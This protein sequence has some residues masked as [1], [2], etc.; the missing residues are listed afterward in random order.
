MGAAAP[1]PPAFDR[2]FALVALA[3][4]PAVAGVV[5][6]LSLRGAPLGAWVA[7][8]LL[9]WAAMGAALWAWGDRDRLGPWLVARWPGWPV[10]LAMGLPVVVLGAMAMRLLARDPLPPPLLIAAALMALADATLEE[11]FWRGAMIPEPTPRAAAAALGLFTAAHVVWV[12]A[13]G[14]ETGGPPWAPLAGAL[15]LGGAWTAS[16]LLTGTVGAGVLGHAGFN[17]F[18]FAQI[19]AL[20]A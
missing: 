5:L 13:P 1:A 8:L 20:N 9:H 10:A 3:A 19:L 6:G 12:A 15:A 16:R 11:L 7:G 14:L 18:A 4:A 2:R 17:L